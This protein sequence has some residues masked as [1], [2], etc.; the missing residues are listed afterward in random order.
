MDRAQDTSRI[1]KTFGLSQT[2][3]YQ[4]LMYGCALAYHASLDGKAPKLHILRV[5]LKGV[6][7]RQRVFA[8][9]K[10]FAEAFLRSVL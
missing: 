2:L 8:F 5:A 3:Q 6:N 10:I 1:L 9:I 7:Q 4:A